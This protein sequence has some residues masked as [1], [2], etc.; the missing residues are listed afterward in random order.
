M[1]YGIRCEEGKR[2]AL[3]HWVETGLKQ[4]WLPMWN[5][6]RIPAASE[7]QNWELAKQMF[8]P[9]VTMSCILGRGASRY[10]D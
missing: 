5:A 3:F 6:P 8:Q 9:V 2:G 7:G 1:G 10:V 4:K